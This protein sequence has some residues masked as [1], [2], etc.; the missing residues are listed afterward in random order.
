MARIKEENEI[1]KKLWPYL[2]QEI[3][4]IIEFIDANKSNH[5]IKT[6]C[7]VLGVARSTYYKSFNKIKSA[8]EVEND[9]LKVDIKYTKLIKVYMEFPEFIIYLLQKALMY[10]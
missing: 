10:L 3:R 5:D 1:L 9:D 4:K 8:R 2:Q 7:S 6:M